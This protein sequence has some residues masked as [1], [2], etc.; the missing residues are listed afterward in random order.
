[1]AG[2]DFTLNP[3]TGCTFGCA[4]CYAAAFVPDE[5]EKKRWG[6][7]VK[8]KVKVKVSGKPYF[9]LS[10]QARRASKGFY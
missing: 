8:V 9:A 5:D 3:Y 10:R 6:E 2:Y 7:C 1:M 4:Y